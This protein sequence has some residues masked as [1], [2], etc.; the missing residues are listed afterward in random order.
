MADLK[1]GGDLAD[2]RLIREPVRGIGS[3]FDSE[4]AVPPFIRRPGPTPAFAFA[5]DDLRPITLDGIYWSSA[6]GKGRMVGVA[7]QAPA[8]VVA[9]TPLARPCRFLAAVLLA[10]TIVHVDTSS[11]GHAPDR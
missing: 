11:V 10:R 2:E 1:T 7:V 9:A 6:A 3:P 5:D 8:A 4:A